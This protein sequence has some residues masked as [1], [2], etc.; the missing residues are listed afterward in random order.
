M[1]SLVS[2]KKERFSAIRAQLITRCLTAC[3]FCFACY[4]SDTE[5]RDLGLQ[6]YMSNFY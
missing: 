5:I 3:L 1:D 2:I 4:V 6:L